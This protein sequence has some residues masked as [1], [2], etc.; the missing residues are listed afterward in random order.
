MGSTSTSALLGC[1]VLLYFQALEPPLPIRDDVINEPYFTGI[2][3][4]EGDLS[5]LRKANELM[6]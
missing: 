2:A 5:L 6:L 3:S 4:P 1:R